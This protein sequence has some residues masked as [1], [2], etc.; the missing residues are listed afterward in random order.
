MKTTYKPIN[1][2]F[3]AVLI[4]MLMV[5]LIAQFGVDLYTD[6]FWFQHLNLTSV[7]FTRLVAGLEVGL[8]AAIPIAVIFLVNVLVARWLSIRNVIFF[9][10]EIL[11]AQKFVG[12]AIWGVGIFLAWLLGSGAASNWLLFLRFLNQ[13]PFDLAD[14]IFGKDVSFYMFSLPIYKFMQSW[15]ML[16]LFLALIGT[17][18]IYALA[19]QNSL[20]GGRMPVI[21]PHI[22]LHLSVLGALI[23]FTFAWGHWL[24][25]F[26][27]MYS[28]RG[29]AFGASYT[30]VNVSMPAHWA[31]MAMAIAAAVTL[32]LNLYLRRPTLSLLAIFVWLVVGVVGN[33]FIPNIVQR[34][35]VEP[36]ELAR[37]SSYIENNIRFTN[38]AYNLDKIVEKEL[39]NPLALTQA[40]VNQ[41]KTTFKNIRLWDYRPLQQ[42]YQQIQ[43]IRLYYHFNDIDLDRYMVNGEL[44]QVALS[45]R[46]LDKNQ[47]KS[48]AW[49]TQKLQFTHGYGVV[50]NPINEV[51]AEGL[52]YLWI[53]DLPPKNLFQTLTISRPQIYYG[54][55]TNDYVFVKTNERE[56]DY[57]SGD[58]NVYTQYEGNGGVLLDSFIKR[59]IFAL[60]LADINLLLSQ[61]ITN[62]SR[63]M[64]YRNIKERV[65]FVAPFLTYDHD[66][67]SVISDDGRLYWIQDAYTTSSLFPNSTPMG[68][69]NYIRNSVKVVID[70]YNGTMT[71]YIVDSH[72]PLIK[73]YAQ[74]FP[75]LFTPLDKMPAWLR[76]HLRYPEDF[77]HIQA[78]LYQTYHMRDANVFYNKEDLWQTPQEV[79][80]GT[81][82]PIE[83]YFVTLPLP[84]EKKEEFLLIQPFTP[85]NKDNLMAWLAARC[86]GENYGKLVVYR[87][88]KQEMIY[89]PLQIEGRI[90]QDPEISSQLTL[91][92][93]GGSKVIRGNLL[94]LPINQ[95]LLYVEPLYIQAENGQIPE[96]KRVIIATG[97]KIFMRSTLDEA[98]MA[99][100]TGAPPITSK[101]L[102][103]E[104]PLPSPDLSGQNVAELV[105]TAAEHYDVAQTALKQ[106]D[107][108]RYGEELAKMKAAIDELVKLTE[109]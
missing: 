19:Q 5:Y 32:L 75:D 33:G 83:P 52:P 1:L 68:D 100:F 28:S 106:G 20:A 49:V 81:T 41:N 2:R 85:N 67:Y 86:D 76:A 3:W 12:G 91:W 37:E 53:K 104:Q 55:T 17:L 62:E 59:V 103:K 22:E 30:D 99:L 82:Q 107:W 18:V 98:L 15:L 60:R 10:D 29:V 94:V 108:A 9:N 14:P 38:I 51:T 71:F 109:K 79:F 102:P 69:L 58:Q 44:R 92:G 84:G 42:T 72:D 11:V 35:M 66:P 56:F 54:E 64:F 57:P 47:L 21:L 63:V 26:D 93:Q 65:N 88:P 24:A 27:L 39:A 45:V 8:A 46:E 25:L 23:F 43:S 97:D 50:V 70:A 31:M 6:Y 96:L 48:Q 36:N 95:A 101:P 87:F 4:A 7:F 78:K 34:Y 74:I 13:Q 105:R 40:D 80:A 16:A 73:I 90:D 89:G 77:F 61:D